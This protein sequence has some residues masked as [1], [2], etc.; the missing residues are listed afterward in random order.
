LLEEE[1]TLELIVL[2]VICTFLR[3]V[4]INIIIA[5]VDFLGVI[6]DEGYL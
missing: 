5:Y 2:L 4:K 6:K 1:Q 3:E